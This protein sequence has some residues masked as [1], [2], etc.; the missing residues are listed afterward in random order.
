MNRIAFGL[1]RAIDSNYNDS[2]RERERERINQKSPFRPGVS[3]SRTIPSDALE[4]A[5]GA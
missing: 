1:M 3:K 2:K 4:L 5:L